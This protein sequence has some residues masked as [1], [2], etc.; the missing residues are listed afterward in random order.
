MNQPAASQ[1]RKTVAYVLVAV[2]GLLILANTGLLSFIGLRDLIAA[3]FQLI[4]NA[5]PYLI[6]LTG[7]V[8]V[9]RSGG[10]AAPLMAWLLVLFG[11]L[12]VVSHIGLFGLSFGAMLTP[13]ILLAVAFFLI[14]PRNLLPRHLN[15][16][17]EDLEPDEQQIKLFAFMGGGELQYHSKHLKGGEVM[18]IWGGY[19][20]DFTDA[21]IEGDSMQLD[22]Y[23]I[24]GGIQITVPAH[25]KVEKN[26]AMCIIGGFSN[27]TRDLAE[28]LNL[29]S[30]TLV[31]SG[32]ALLGGGEI[33]N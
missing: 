10:S 20:I 19:E 8:W 12:L 27:R 23:C 25:W 18:A 5:L 24:M 14:N 29:P 28:E 31:V 11:A 32:L 4:F 13:A 26:D 22:V 2:A 21:D 6:T 15:T 17:N 7:I 9:A 3:V 30:K 1:S 33:R 16:S